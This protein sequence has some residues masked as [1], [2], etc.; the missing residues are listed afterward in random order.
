[1]FG[2]RYVVYPS[3]RSVPFGTTMSTQTTTPT[4]VKDEEDPQ[5]TGGKK[6]SFDS[7]ENSQRVLKQWLNQPIIR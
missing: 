4:P 6:W 1:M 2:K 7:G 3:Q 5:V